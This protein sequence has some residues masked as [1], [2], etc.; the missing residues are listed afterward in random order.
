MGTGTLHKP[1]RTL[2]TGGSGWGDV[3]VVDTPASVAD[4]PRGAHL[5]LRAWHAEPGRDR[6][7]PR[8]RRNRSRG[9][10]PAVPGVAAPPAHAAR[11]PGPEPSRE[12]HRLRVAG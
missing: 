12:R 11:E 6:R 5:Q 2:S 9:R 8:R 10:R 1:G 7:P 4:C 3:V